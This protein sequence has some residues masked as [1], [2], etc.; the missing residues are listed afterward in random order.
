MTNEEISDVRWMSDETQGR[1]HAHGE[2]ETHLFRQI[3]KLASFE[4]TS[5]DSVTK[6]RVCLVFKV[7]ADPSHFYLEGEKQPGK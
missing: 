4:F 2:D 5:D 1:G 6:A 3:A 7:H